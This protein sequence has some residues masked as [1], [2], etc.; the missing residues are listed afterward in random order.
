MKKINLSLSSLEP[1]IQKISDLTKLQRILVCI[2]SVGVVI[3]LFVWLLYLPQINR[4]SQLGKDIAAE[5]DKLKTTKA[6]ADEFDKYQ[7]LMEEKKAQ[8]NIVSKQL[9]QTDEVP[10]L[11]R[12][13][14]QAGKEAGLSFLLFQPEAERKKNFYAEIPVRMNLTGSY[15]DLGVFF[16]TVAGMSRIVNIES[17]GITLPKG[18]TV[19]SFKSQGGSPQLSISCQAVTYKFIESAAP[20]EKESAGKKAPAKGKK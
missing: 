12:N 13:I 3:G 19:N 6:N 5:S 14:S 4:Q 11:L 20:G 17:F 7:S 2:G 8:F 9:P 10:A 1:L 16:D 15:S 18:K